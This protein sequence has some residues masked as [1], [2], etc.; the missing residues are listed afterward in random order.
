MATD[1][2][3]KSGNQ[4]RRNNARRSAARKMQQESPGLRYQEAMD[5]LAGTSPTN[6]ARAPHLSDYLGMR[7]VQDITTH[8]RRA[9]GA[10]PDLRI[11]IG[12][13]PDGVLYMNLEQAR[14]AGTGPHTFIVGGTPT[15]RNAASSTM[16]TA[17]RAIN[18][19]AALEVV[20][21]GPAAAS[22]GV[23]ADMMFG[24]EDAQ[25]AFAAWLDVEIV[26][27]QIV[28]QKEALPRR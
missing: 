26:R 20:W 9:G 2:T 18:A 8:Y 27:R 12:A 19:P 1:S 15:A 23:S 11:P 28:L 17:L 7:T 24:G 13:G 10:E 22:S 6:S 4:K 5:L 16:C 25:D 3:G 14:R 21:A